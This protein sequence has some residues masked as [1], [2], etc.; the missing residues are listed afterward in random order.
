MLFRDAEAV[1]PILSGG[2]LEA[3]AL[4]HSKVVQRGVKDG[5]ADQVD[6]YGVIGTTWSDTCS[7]CCVGETWTVSGEINKL[8]QDECVPGCDT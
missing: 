8:V 7:R 2:V 3:P 1:E 5:Q 4:S 6:E